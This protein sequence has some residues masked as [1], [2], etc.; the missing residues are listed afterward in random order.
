MHVTLKNFV[1]YKLSTLICKLQ[2]E[3]KLQLNI[4][5]FTVFF[6]SLF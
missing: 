6:S 3:L 5:H 4:L 2:M 1:I